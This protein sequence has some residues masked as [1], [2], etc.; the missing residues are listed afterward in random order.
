MSVV[1][2]NNAVTTLAA[3]VSTSGT[4]LTVDD[5]SSFPTISLTSHTYVTLQDATENKEVVKVTA[6]NGNTFTVVRAR[7]NTTARAFS[8]GDKVE[9]RLTAVLLE[10]ISDKV[11]GLTGSGTADVT[12]T[13]PNFTVAGPTVVSALT[14]DSNFLNNTDTISGGNF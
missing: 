13:Y 7:D 1:F 2:S 14:N 4:T 10:E 3:S 9:L 12:G 5:G 8:I 11:V 6:I